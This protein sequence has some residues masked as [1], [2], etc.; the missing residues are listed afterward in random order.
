[1]KSF[2][3]KS[4]YAIDILRRLGMLDYKSISTP[5]ISKLKKLQDQATGLDPEDLTIIGS[6]MYLIHT[7]PD[8][9]HAVNALYQFM[10]EPKHIHM[11]VVKHILRYVQET[12]AYGLRY[13]LVEV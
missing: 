2:S 11:I 6:L 13:T 9:Y 8:I 3:H 12:I 1:V 5:M 10:Y 4:K 7:R